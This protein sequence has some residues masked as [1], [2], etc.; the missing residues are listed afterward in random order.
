M[1]LQCL[2]LI[3]EGHGSNGSDSF[4]NVVFSLLVVVS[5]ILHLLYTVMFLHCG[6]EKMKV[7]TRLMGKFLV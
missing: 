6:M 1:I 2:E 7:T 4:K 5:A 3:F